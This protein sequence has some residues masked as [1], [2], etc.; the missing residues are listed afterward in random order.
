LSRWF[1]LFL[2]VN[3]GT[4]S[5]Q[6]CGGNVSSCA[7]EVAPVSCGLDQDCHSA[8]LLA[9][10]SLIIDPRSILPSLRRG[11]WSASSAATKPRA[12]LLR[13]WKAVRLLRSWVSSNHGLWA[14]ACDGAEGG[15]WTV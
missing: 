8:W 1:I 14:I 3:G 15:T 12:S 10:C 13:S 4:G 2:A 7:D 9:I 6:G 11:G 5:R